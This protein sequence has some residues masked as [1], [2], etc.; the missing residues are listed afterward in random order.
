[1]AEQSRLAARLSF[2]LAAAVAVVK[3]PLAQL[4][5]KGFEHDG[6]WEQL[7]IHDK[8]TIPGLEQ[9][10]DRAEAAQGTDRTD[11]ASGQD[12]DSDSDE[13]DSSK[14]LHEKD[15]DED[16]G[17]A[18]EAASGGDD[19]GE[20][21]EHLARIRKRAMA[22]E[23]GSDDDSEDSDG[24]DDEPSKPS[25]TGEE[26]D[27]EV[28]TWTGQLRESALPVDDEG[29]TLEDGTFR[30]ND[31]DRFLEDMDEAQERGLAQEQPSLPAARVG[32][33]ASREDDDASDEDDE[34]EEEE[35]DVDF[36]SRNPTAALDAHERALAGGSIVSAATSSSGSMAGLDSISGY[37]EKMRQQAAQQQDE[38]AKKKG[39]ASSKVPPSLP[40][41]DLG[42]R[43][44][45]S[46]EEAMERI[47]AEAAQFDDFFGP[48][49]RSDSS[50]GHHRDGGRRWDW[51]R[52][53][54]DNDNDN[55]DDE[56]NDDQEEDD[57]EDDDGRKRVRFAADMDAG[58]APAQYG[59]EE[60]EDEAVAESSEGAAAMSSHEVR[61]AAL[62]RQIGDLEQNAVDAY[63]H[64]PWIMRGEV[65]AGARPENSL[66]EAVVEHEAAMR[67]P[68]QLTATA[69]AALEDLIRRRI[70][71]E[72]FDDPERRD[73]PKADL[74]ATERQEELS[75]EKAAR[76]LGDEYEE[77]FKRDAMGQK[78]VSKVEALEKDVSSLWAA[79]SGRLDAL[80]HMTYTPR[81]TEDLADDDEE[82]EEEL[83][84]GKRGGGVTVRDSAPALSME[85]VQPTMG[86][87]AA[88]LA[89]AGTDHATPNE[90]R[91]V[92]RGRAGVQ[93]GDSE[94]APDEK[95][96]RRRAAK[97]SRRR[98]R[99]DK[100][101]AQRLA[102]RVNPGMGNKHETDRLVK[103]L[104]AGGNKAVTQGREAGVTHSDFATSSKFFSRMQDEAKREAAKLAAA[105]AG[106]TADSSSSSRVASVSKRS[107]KS[108]GKR[109]RA[110]G[111]ASV[112]L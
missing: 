84:S 112:M 24:E 93:V 50:S 59:D 66:L 57:D 68:P 102:D 107:R 101:A 25:K 38:G 2:N 85:D 41:G 39:R 19:D 110:G 78:G 83:G 87:A 65:G 72:L 10:L 92:V 70:A 20:E 4:H 89:A 9:L 40:T 86:P 81:M 55:D 100:A 46:K 29:K 33:E 98:V 106:E 23:Q 32:R 34:S 47:R 12:D 35:P 82:E 76:G 109:S 60:D 15:E 67:P 108:K 99:R 13:S 30:W 22:F 6:V 96:T 71:D 45:E 111:A 77:A 11:S 7:R 95:Q 42:R 80:A 31:M 64:K 91:A 69:T 48:R 21:D 63:M 75:T 53:D 44:G 27:P 49:G 58:Q 105:S 90:I 5:T 74:G 56:E 16:E 62:R 8:Q 73:R 43:L 52:D 3:G 26:L 88:S 14:G 54:N 28:Y 97:A 18:D 104:L 17:S 51:G 61:Q 103:E 36:F 37:L 1:L 79:L 94:L